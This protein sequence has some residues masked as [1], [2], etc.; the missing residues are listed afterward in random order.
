M[1]PNSPVTSFIPKKSVV[2][3]AAPRQE[4]SV[5]LM[6]AFVVIVFLVTLVVGGGM[7]LWERASLAQL[8]SSKKNLEQQKAK[9]QPEVIAQFQRID[10]R[11]GVASELL[12]QHHSPLKF[13]SLIQ[14][15]VYKDVSFSNVSYAR[16]EKEIKATFNGEAKDYQ[17]I[18]LQSDFLNTNK[19]IK[20]YLFTNLSPKEN[21]RISFSLLLIVD[22]DFVLSKD[23]DIRNT[24]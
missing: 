18:I 2:E 15:V 17:T 10:T 5:G 23:G 8:E 9:F 6:T 7:F 22:P 11:M 13:F 14:S 12:A 3:E 21:G 19:Y 16:S 4:S 20:E 24:Q 1:E